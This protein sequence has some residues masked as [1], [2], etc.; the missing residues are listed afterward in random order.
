MGVKIS[1]LQ[2]I[3]DLQELTDEDILVLVDKETNATKKI[4]YGNLS[5]KILDTISD[6]YSLEE[7]QIGT[8]VD[9]RPIYRKTIVGTTDFPANTAEIR[10]EHNITDIAVCIGEPKI[11]V[12]EEGAIFPHVAND[13][14]YTG[15]QGIGK[16]YITLK[17]LSTKWYDLPKN[18]YITLEY[19][20]TQ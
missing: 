4:T 10:F 9:G 3:T 8:W 12:E 14:T 20:K 11:F 19:L 18:V 5:K 17:N 15:F 16:T 6:D 7:K 1:E 13:G 2:E